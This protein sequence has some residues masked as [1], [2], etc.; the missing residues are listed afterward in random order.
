MESEKITTD[1]RR[2]LIEINRNCEKSLGT[3]FETL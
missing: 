1:M 3:G 2:E